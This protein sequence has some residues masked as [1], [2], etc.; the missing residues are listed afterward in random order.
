LTRQKTY[1]TLSCI[2]HLNHLSTTTN[3]SNLSPSH[4]KEKPTPTMPQE[5]H[6]IYDSILILDFGSQV[7]V[8]CR[9]GRNMV[10]MSLGVVL[11]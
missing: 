1:H 6:D 8:P 7:R 10:V 11:G 9:S 5:I 3:G 2:S 4:R